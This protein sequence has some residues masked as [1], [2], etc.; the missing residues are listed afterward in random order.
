MLLKH[1]TMVQTYRPI[2]SLPSD[3]RQNAVDLDRI[4]ARL[5]QIILNPDVPQEAKL[6]KSQ[7]E[8]QRIGNV[9]PAIH[10][11]VWMRAE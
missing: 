11:P 10:E 9:Y 5:Q 3:A 2:F 7:Y 6:R 8:R 1:V 4:V